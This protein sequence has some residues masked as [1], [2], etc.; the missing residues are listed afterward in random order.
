METGQF[1]PPPPPTPPFQHPLTLAPPLLYLSQ[2]SLNTNWSWEGG[3]GGPP[4]E[5]NFLWCWCGWCG[6]CWVYDKHDEVKIL[7]MW[8]TLHEHD[9]A[10]RCDAV[11][12]MMT[13]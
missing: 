10:M 4:V 12:C 13:T 9:V 6:C 11:E 8:S 7:F 1:T 5:W 2:Y 3:R